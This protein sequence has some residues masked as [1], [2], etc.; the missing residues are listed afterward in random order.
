M[1][2]LLID[3]ERAIR[4]ALREILEF[5]GCVVEEAEN[6][7]QALDK[8][9]AQSFELIFS[10]IKMPQMDG[11]ELLDQILA[12]GIETPVIMISGHGTVETAVGAIKKGDFD[13]EVPQLR[14]YEKTAAWL[15]D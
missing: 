9:K 15:W 8:L 7:T 11:L 12:L 13:K 6:G 5:E 4:R 2:V 3:D 14:N 10:D 1:Q